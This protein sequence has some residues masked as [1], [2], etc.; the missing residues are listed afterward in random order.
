MNKKIFLSLAIITIA[1]AAMG[2]GTMA[3]FTDEATIDQNIFETGTVE[4]DATDVFNYTNNT[5]QDW[6][7]G[8]CV[9]KEIKINYTGSKN[10][11]L[12]MQITEEWSG[13]TGGSSGLNGVYTQRNAPN[14]DWEGFE[15]DDWVYYGD[16]WYY[17]GEGEIKINIGGTDVGNIVAG[18]DEITILTRVCLDGAETGNDFQDAEYTINA[19]FQAI[20]AS[21]AD[22]WDWDNVDFDTGLE[23]DN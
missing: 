13:I 19:T 5:F 22:Q 10:A 23:L 8:E 11:F 9:D 4:L 20:Q 16:W 15:E 17:D 2:G 7:P 18:I 6:N 1:I 21:S 3:W 14:V 12:R